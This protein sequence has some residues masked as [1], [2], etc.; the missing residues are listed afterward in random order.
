MKWRPLMER[1]SGKP[2]LGNPVGASLRRI[3]EVDRSQKGAH[4]QHQQIDLH[5]FL[6]CLVATYYKPEVRKPFY[7]SNDSH[8]IK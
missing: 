3:G 7:T 6:R 2:L 5:V 1:R 4:Q 8:V